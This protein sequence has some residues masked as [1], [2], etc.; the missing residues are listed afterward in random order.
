MS[1]YSAHPVL[2]TKKLSGKP[3]LTQQRYLRTWVGA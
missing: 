3:M 2:Q 1:K